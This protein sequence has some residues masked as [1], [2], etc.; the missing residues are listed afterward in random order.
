RSVAAF[1]EAFTTDEPRRY[2]APFVTR[3]QHKEGR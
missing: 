2:M 3:K 1:G